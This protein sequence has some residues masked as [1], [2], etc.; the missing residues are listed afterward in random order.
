[1]SHNMQKWAASQAQIAAFVSQTCLMPAVVLDSVT[2]EVLRHLKGQPQA[3]A[4]YDALRSDE[5]TDYIVARSA[6]VFENNASFRKMLSVS[7]PRPQYYAFVRH[8]VA[9][10]IKNKFPQ[11]FDQ[12]PSEFCVGAP[13]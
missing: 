11:L 9:G 1:M 6:V 3:G 2:G 7:D 4:L 8:W 10:V 12:L 5:T 13:L